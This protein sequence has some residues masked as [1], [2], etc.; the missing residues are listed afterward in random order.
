MK[1]T[2]CI[3][4]Y[5]EAFGDGDP[6]FEKALFENC[7]C[8]C[9]YSQAEGKISSM[10]FALPCEIKN[11]SDTLE[12]KYI[13]AVATLKEMQSKGYMTRLLRGYT[14]SCNSLLFLR[15]A[16]KALIEF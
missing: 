4:I 6:A 15:P 5:R 14:E 11:E 9:A 16:N 10:F 3:K 1:K 13:Y 2:E 7:F 8:D 12:A